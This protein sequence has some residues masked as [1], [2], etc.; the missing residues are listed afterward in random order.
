MCLARFDDLED[1]A[2]LDARCREPPS[3]PPTP[4]SRPHEGDL[5][6]EKES[7]QGARGR[8]KQFPYI[9]VGTGLEQ[10]GIQ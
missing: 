5:Y 1:P 10:T 9:D 3:G 4:R 6:V 2:L 8:N 7:R